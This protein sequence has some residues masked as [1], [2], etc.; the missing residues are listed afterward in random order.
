MDII[1]GHADEWQ[2]FMADWPAIQEAYNTEMT[3]AER[4]EVL[5]DYCESINLAFDMTANMQVPGT[6]PFWDFAIGVLI[7][8]GFEPVC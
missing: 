7:D 6:S 3:N 2:G 4:L 8:S 5:E 1:N